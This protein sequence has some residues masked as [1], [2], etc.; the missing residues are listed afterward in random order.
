MTRPPDQPLCGQGK[1][2]LAEG[3]QGV[4]QVGN[5]PLLRQCHDNVRQKDHLRITTIF[6][7][8]QIQ[9]HLANS[10][11]QEPFPDSAGPREVELIAESGGEE[12]VVDVGQSEIV[13]IH[14][15]V[16]L[17]LRL[18]VTTG[19]SPILRFSFLSQQHS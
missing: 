18:L 1:V 10:S 2:G 8:K 13:G 3:D 16:L 4:H 12:E 5:N 6:V 7:R 19:A 17:L 14:H 11:R 9:P 15:D